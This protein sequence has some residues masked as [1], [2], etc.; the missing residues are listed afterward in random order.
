MFSV[1]TFLGT[2]YFKLLENEEL[3]HLQHQI[4]LDE[5]DLSDQIKSIESKKHALE[6]KFPQINESDMADIIFTSGTTGKPKGGNIDSCT[7]YKSF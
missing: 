4:S 2:N 3:P 6:A 1:K 7:K 5:N